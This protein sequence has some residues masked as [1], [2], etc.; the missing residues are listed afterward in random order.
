[1]QLK[2]IESRLLEHDPEF[3]ED[4][5]ADRRALRRHYLLNAFVRGLAPT[6]PLSDYDPERNVEQ[7]SQL[8]LNMERIRVPE[9]IYEP[10][11]AGLD[12]AGLLEIIEN[13]LRHFSLD[14]RNRLTKVGDERNRAAEWRERMLLLAVMMADLICLLVSDYLRD[15]RQHPHAAL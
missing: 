14:E 2:L 6:D 7:A 13:M 8:H 3:T 1:M 10:H 15:R 9:V 11:M 12:C 4:D 5:T